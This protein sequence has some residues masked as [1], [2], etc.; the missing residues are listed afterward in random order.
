MTPFRPFEIPSESELLSTAKPTGSVSGYAQML[1][2]T[3]ISKTPESLRRAI[4]VAL[5]R[6]AALGFVYSAIAWA[7]KA[8]E[9]AMSPVEVGFEDK[10]RLIE[11][12]Q[13]GRLLV[14]LPEN[15]STGYR[16]ELKSFTHGILELQ[17]EGYESPES[18]I[19]GAGGVRSFTFIALSRGASSMHMRLRRPWEPEQAAGEVFHVS[20]EVVATSGSGLDGK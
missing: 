17:S 15:P 16:W 8:E 7:G 14:R 6:L 9:P 13:G 1:D 18:L 5:I 10:G 20:V 11:L 3:Q 4:A 2:T 12:H 19:P